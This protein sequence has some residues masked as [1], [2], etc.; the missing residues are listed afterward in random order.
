MFNGFYNVCIRQEA[1]F[2]NHLM[3][4]HLKRHRDG[5]SY[6]DCSEE[7]FK[8]LLHICRE[9]A[10]E[11]PDVLSVDEQVSYNAP[12][13]THIGKHYF[14]GKMRLNDKQIEELVAKYYPNE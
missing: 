4:A 8:K 12:L 5:D 9:I 1:D 6:V 7:D 2:T 13:T 14:A 10:T 3:L 11:H